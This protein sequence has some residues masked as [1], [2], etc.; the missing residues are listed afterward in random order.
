MNSREHRTIDIVNM[1]LAFTLVTAF[2]KLFLW[3]WR[4]SKVGTILAITI[5]PYF[6]IYGNHALDDLRAKVIC[7]AKPNQDGCVLI[8]RRQALESSWFK[9]AFNWK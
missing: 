4:K 6:L 9:Q 3:S 7:D 5:G 1:I 2:L 8:R